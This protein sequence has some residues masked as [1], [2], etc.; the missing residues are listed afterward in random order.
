MSGRI[1]MRRRADGVVELRIDNPRKFNAMSL[2]MWQDLGAKLRE[3]HADRSVRVLL[4]RGEGE[5]AFVSG[6]DI[7]E[8]DSVR[9]A[10]SGSET[11]D[12]AV[13]SAQAA[14]A[15]APFPIVA[16]IHGV[17]MGGGLGLAMACDLRY[18]SVDARLRMPA[19]RLGL[20]YSYSGI[21]QMVAAIGGARVGELFYTARTFG[22]AEAERLGLVHAAY[23]AEALDHEVEQ[24]LSQIAE[25]APLTL[26]LVKNAIRLATA[27]TADG[28]E[29]LA[30]ERERQACVRSGDYAEGRRAFA[31]KRQ[32]RFTGE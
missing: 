12:L 15:R 29:V 30:L 19:A 16:C 7:S 1:L 26:R 20:G 32:P 21:R 6:A 17:C 3:L 24:I 8:F 31:E 2:S 14:L 28:E 4:L 11:Y 22:G 27:A 9:S 23:P 25:N 5:R 10:E 18:A 13:E